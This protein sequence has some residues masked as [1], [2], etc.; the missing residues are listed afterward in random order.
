MSTTFTCSRRHL[1]LCN[2]NICYY[3]TEYPSEKYL[4]NIINGVSEGKYEDACKNGYL[5]GSWNPELLSEDYNLS[6]SITED[7]YGALIASFLVSDP[8][9]KLW[10]VYYNTLI[11]AFLFA[12]IGQISALHYIYV[13][14]QGCKKNIYK[15]K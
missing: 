13:I 11:S 1:L 12:V 8:A 15:M 10:L 7:I 5:F 3:A 2:W 6:Y 9:S 14:V 4:K